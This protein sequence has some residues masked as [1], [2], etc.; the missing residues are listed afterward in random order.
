DSKKIATFQQDQRRVSDMY[1]VDTTVGHPNLQAWKYPLPG[2]DTVTMIHR[3]IIDADSGKIVRFQMPPDQHRSTLC[4][5]LQR[6]SGYGGEGASG[7][8]GSG[9]PTDRPSRSSRPPVIIAASSC[10]SPTLRAARCAT[11]SRK[12]LKRSSNRGTARSTGGICR[13]R[14]RRSGSRSATT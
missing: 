9:A 8:T 6:R 7:E 11:S 4:D 14:T 1:L 3:V 10:A 5:D 2:D 12:R 13:D